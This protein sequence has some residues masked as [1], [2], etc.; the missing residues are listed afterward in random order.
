MI[1]H[2]LNGVINKLVRD[3][4]LID[5]ALQEFSSKET[6]ISSSSSD[7]GK[8]PRYEFFISRLVRLHWDWAHTPGGA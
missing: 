6:A 3:A 4:L 7:V 8:E 5:H 2:V 1:V